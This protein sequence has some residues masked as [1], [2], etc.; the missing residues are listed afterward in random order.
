MERAR[1]VGEPAEINVERLELDDRNLRHLAEH[2][3][4]GDAVEEVL[5]IAPQFFTNLP[6]R[7]G[8]H[9]MVGPDANGRFLFVVLSEG[10]RRGQWRVITAYR[11]NH[12]RALRFYR[13]AP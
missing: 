3:V 5:S 6:D 13:E 11:Y 7:S 1:L 12:R 10:I 8:T 2:G 4:T 9:V